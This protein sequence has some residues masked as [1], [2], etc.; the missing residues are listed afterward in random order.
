MGGG[1]AGLTA[2]HELVDRGYDV[3]V[4]E[5]GAI[6]GG[7]ARSFGMPGSGVGGRPDLPAEHGFRFFPGFYQH[8]PNTM[9]RIP[10]EGRTVEDNLVPASRLMLA[11][12][13]AGENFLSVKFPAT[14]FHAP[15]AWEALFGSGSGLTDDDMQFFANRLWVLATS[16]RARRFDEFEKRSW[17]DFI[18]AANRPP[19]YQRLLGRGL[20]Q[21][22]VAMKAQ[23]GSTRTVGLILL[24]LL[25][26]MVEPK[27][28]LDDWLR[29]RFG[30]DRL[31]NGPTND[32]WIDPWVAWLQSRGV[33]FRFGTAVT[34]LHLAAGRVAR[35]SV[36][37]GTV[38]D[39]A[40]DH[41]V[42]ALPAERVAALLTP[43]VLSLDP[44]LAGIEMLANHHTEWMNGFMYYLHE[45]L[46]LVHGHTIYLDSAWAL[47]TLEQAQ[48]WRRPM[49]AFGDG[50]I[51]SVLSVDVSDWNTPGS[52]AI[53]GG[54]PA[55]ACSHQQLI[56]EVWFQLQQ[57]LNDGAQP[58]LPP[59]YAGAHVDPAIV[60]DP[61]LGANTNA[62]PLLVNERDTWRHRPHAATAIPNLFLAGD[63]VRTNTDLA[64]MEGANEAARHAVNEILRRDRR[65]ARRCCIWPLSEPLTLRPFKA[66][67]RVRYSLGLKHSADP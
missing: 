25:L 58:L 48:F 11:Q 5:K 55:R 49:S 15:A 14:L 38:Y 41:Y 44:A 34:K 51:R 13:G 42:C 31:L 10:F 45:E 62:E 57:H 37:D 20:T 8:L 33:E 1:V 46:D 43:Q 28:N 39:L 66:A 65:W 21:T 23:K 35:L 18:D 7:K 12:A 6:A 16:C 30:A 4:L 19:A 53:T 60:W 67:D 26:D 47:T 63:Y 29:G 24:Q 52:A 40:A 61:A 17:W 56:D 2:A 22:L 36:D 3:V 54:K 9:R 32:V 64:T 27:R 50:T 59:A